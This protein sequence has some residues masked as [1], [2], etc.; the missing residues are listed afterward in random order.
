MERK[1]LNSLEIV[2][3]AGQL[4]DKVDIWLI[5][6]STEQVVIN[7]VVLHADVYLQH[8]YRTDLRDV[9]SNPQL[10]VGSAVN[11]LKEYI[12]KKLEKSPFKKLIERSINK[13]IEAMSDGLT[14]D[15]VTADQ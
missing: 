8:N 2:D 12:M 13:L 14:L 1:P 4:N 15:L 7:S 11:E 5:G 9:I 6:E 3:V 10:H